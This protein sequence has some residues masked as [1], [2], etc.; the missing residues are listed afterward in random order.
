M[1]SLGTRGHT[2]D[3]YQVALYAPILVVYGAVIVL[4]VPLFYWLVL[5]IVSCCDAAV[6]NLASEDFVIPWR[7]GLFTLPQLIFKLYEE[8]EDINGKKKIFLSGRQLLP[9]KNE[10]ET[11]TL[12]VMVTL[13]INSASIIISAALVFWY[14]FLLEETF[15]CDPGLD[16]FALNSKDQKPLD[17]HRIE[18]CS[19]FEM[20]DNVTIEC[21]QYVFLIGTGF[22]AFGGLLSFGEVI[23]Q[24]IVNAVFWL[25]DASPKTEPEPE[26]D[27]RESTRTNLKKFICWLYKTGTKTVI[28]LLCISPFIITVVVF[29]IILSTNIIRE[30]ASIVKISLYL[31]T[32]IILVIYISPLAILAHSL[33][34][35]ANN[36]SAAGGRSLSA[37]TGSVS[38][39]NVLTNQANNA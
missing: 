12:F 23:L 30:K 26:S 16:C 19:D 21:Y 7:R 14:V 31:A 36:G 39:T 6:N 34:K 3:H 1:A 15:T 28:F 27:G 32:S 9:V 38:T 5:K 25:I 24:I 20:M 35:E 13:S 17:G 8:K 11:F 22:S 33:P 4:Y 29:T 2:Y 10:K 18:N 37:N